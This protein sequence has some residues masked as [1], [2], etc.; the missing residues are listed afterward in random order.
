[1][2]AAIRRAKE[3]RSVQAAV[4]CEAANTVPHR[5]DAHTIRSQRTKV[6]WRDREAA[7]EETLPPRLE[8]RASRNNAVSVP[9]SGILA[10]SIQSPPA[11]ETR[12]S[13]PASAGAGGPANSSPA[14]R[15]WIATNPNLPAA[16]SINR[17]HS[18]AL[19][20][21]ATCFC[22]AVRSS[23]AFRLRWKP[24][25]KSNFPARENSA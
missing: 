15:I 6:A 20:A 13:H 14:I 24:P 18:A 4:S 21:F 8:F 22:S 17:A 11:M 23:W 3:P 7:I 1:M 16:S 25:P 5:W 12:A 10:K 9:E 2:R 19:R